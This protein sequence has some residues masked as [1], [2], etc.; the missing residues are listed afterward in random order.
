MYAQYN[1]IQIIYWTFSTRTNRIKKKKKIT[2]SLSPT[3][4]YIH[5]TTNA[6]LHVHVQIISICDPIDTSTHSA[7]IVTH[8]DSISPSDDV[9]LRAVE[10]TNVLVGHLNVVKLFDDPLGHTA[11]PHTVAGKRRSTMYMH[12]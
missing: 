9:S 8:S 6:L 7:V 11:S 3:A 2:R 4:S 12:M 1:T 10:D 5:C